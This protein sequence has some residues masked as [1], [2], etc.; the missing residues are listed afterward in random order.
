MNRYYQLTREQRYQISALRGTG[1]TQ[2]EIASELDVAPSTISRELRR[3]ATTGRYDPQAAD[4]LSRERRRVAPKAKRITEAMWARAD[5]LLCQEWSPEQVSYRLKT[6]EGIGI[7]HESIYRRVRRD[8]ADGGDLYTY[9]RHGF[10]RRRKYGKRDLR[11]HI[12][13]RVSIDH[14]PAVVDER[15]RIVD[16]ELDTV[17]GTRR[18]GLVTAVERKAGLARLGKVSRRGAAEVCR[19]TLGRFQAERDLVLTLTSDNG[20]EFADH[21]QLRDGLNADFYFAHPYSSWER[22]TNENTNGLVRQYFPKGTDFD[23][24]EPWEIQWVEDRLNNRP[25]KRLGWA[26]P[27]EVYYGRDWKAEST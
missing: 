14:R 13:G 20:K 10:K 18:N 1:L 25:R 24:I 2:K 23:E 15:S 4:T 16:W 21:K 6:R 26:T 5:E 17:H 3:N 22:G 8:K 27:N 11:G 7:S 9:L 19:T 12:R